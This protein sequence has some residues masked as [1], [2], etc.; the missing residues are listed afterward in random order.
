MNIAKTWIEVRN[1]VSTQMD[2]LMD[3]L[4]RFNLKRLLKTSH[5]ED[6][7]APTTISPD[8]HPISG[9][10]SRLE[11]FLDCGQGMPSAAHAEHHSDHEAQSCQTC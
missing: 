5:H 9:T 1:Y 4:K 11:L 2:M 7:H 3:L 10:A 8:A 6:G